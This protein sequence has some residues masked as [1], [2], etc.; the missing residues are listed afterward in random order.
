MQRTC[1]WDGGDVPPRTRR[2]TVTRPRG[3]RSAC[4]PSHRHRRPISRNRSSHPRRDH[5]REMVRG[6][7]THLGRRRAPA[8]REEDL[9]LA[10]PSRIDR[11]LARRWVR[12][13]VLVVE[14]GPEVPERDPGRFAGPA[15][16]DQLRL[17]RQHRP[18][19]LDRPGS[20]RL[21]AS[22]K[23]EVADDDPQ[24]SHP[25]RIAWRR[26]RP[27]D[28]D[29]FHPR[30]RHRR[31]HPGGRGPCHALPARRRRQ[32]RGDAGPDRRRRPGSRPPG[33][34]AVPATT[35]WFRLGRGGF[36]ERVSRG[37]A[38]HRRDPELSRPAAD[39]RSRL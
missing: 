1:I 19:R 30:P 15:A 37:P 13:V 28:P 9:A 17:D 7:R 35:A 8:V 6:Q 32:T 24:G 33:A 23:V 27:P 14:T 21:P 38:H 2:R 16:V 26:A 39:G 12:R 11:Q 3:S 22:A 29:D 20:G 5:G 25:R 31:G 18:D 4:A 34:P 36:F 10:D